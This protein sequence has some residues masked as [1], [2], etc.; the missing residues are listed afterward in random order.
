MRRMSVGMGNGGGVMTIANAAAAVHSPSNSPSKRAEA[1][2]QE[3]RKRE[4]AA[5]AVQAFNSIPGTDIPIDKP[6][7]EHW[8]TTL[9]LKKAREEA[10]LDRDHTSRFMESESKWKGVPVWKRSLLERRQQDKFDAEA[11]MRAAEERARKEEEAFYS[12]PSWKQAL[13]IAKRNGE[14]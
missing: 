9:K 11:P 2:Y 14:Y 13:V 12:M 8:K 10:A 6:A 1:A 7:G 3:Q 4:M 5:R